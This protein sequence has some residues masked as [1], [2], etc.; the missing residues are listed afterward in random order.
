MLAYRYTRS[1]EKRIPDESVDLDSVDI[2]E[3]LDSLLDLPL[4]CLDVDNEDERVVLLD[5][6]HRTLGVER[7]DDDTAGIEARNVRYRLAR[8]LGC[9][10][11][12]EGLRAVEGRIQANLA[13]LVRVD[14]FVGTS[15][16]RWDADTPQGVY[17]VSYTHLTLP[18][19][20]IV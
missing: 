7:V 11:K 16:Q 15:R 2:V 20:R 19:K 18:T 8:V 13:D 12:T 17:A 1:S 9:A 5:L 6:L 4:V 3:G 14:L 10:G